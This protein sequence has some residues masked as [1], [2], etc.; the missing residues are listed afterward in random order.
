MLDYLGLEEEFTHK[1]RA[2]RDTIREFAD[3][4]REE[5]VE[6][7]REGQFPVER[8]PEMGDLGFSPRISTGTGWRGRRTAPTG[9]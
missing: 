9:S 6:S 8:I 1:E 7:Y 3:D 5:M 2:A 4:A